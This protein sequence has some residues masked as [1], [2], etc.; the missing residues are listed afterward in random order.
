MSST[1]KPTCNTHG[2]TSDS[3]TSAHVIDVYIYTVRRKIFATEKFRESLPKRGGRN[4]RD[5]NIREGGSDTLRNTIT[6]LL[7]LCGSSDL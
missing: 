3:S 6:W 1:A 7:R 2:H 4:I 5:K